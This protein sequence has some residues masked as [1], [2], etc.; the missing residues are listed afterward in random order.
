MNG[1]DSGQRGLLFLEWRWRT[2][3]DGTRYVTDMAFLLRQPD[4][5]TQMV[6]DR[7]VLGLFPRATWLELIAG[8]GFQPLA[9]PFEHSTNPDGVCE[10]FLGLRPAR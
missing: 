5:S 10:V 6:Q 4:G 8:A 1:S 7:H 3:P 9:V 2:E